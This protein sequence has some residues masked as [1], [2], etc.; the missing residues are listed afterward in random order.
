M[1]THYQDL[2]IAYSHLHPFISHEDARWLTEH[3]ALTSWKKSEMLKPVPCLSVNV[4]HPQQAII[5][6]VWFIYFIYCTIS[7]GI[8]VPNLVWK[9]VTICLK[10]TNSKSG[11]QISSNIWCDVTKCLRINQNCHELIFCWSITSITKPQIKQI[12]L[13]CF[14][15]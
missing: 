10:A 6:V 1:V 4:W 15:N 3:L 9:T 14:I 2:T 5:L 12:E 11:N 13:N 7:R 8:K